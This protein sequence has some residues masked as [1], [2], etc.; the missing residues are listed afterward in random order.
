MAILNHIKFIGKSVLMVKMFRMLTETDTGDNL[1]FTL[2]IVEDNLS[3]FLEL[4]KFF[5]G[6]LKLFNCA[7]Y[8]SGPNYL[9]A[10]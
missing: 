3:F 2:L 6:L 1:N 7:K 5:Y 4:N 10:E 9:G 8:D